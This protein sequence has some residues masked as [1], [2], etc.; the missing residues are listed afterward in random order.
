MLIWI[1][2]NHFWHQFLGYSDVWSI[3]KRIQIHLWIKFCIA[4]FQDLWK[5]SAS[6]AMW[7]IQAINCVKKAQENC[8]LA[9]LKALSSKV[10]WGVIIN[11]IGAFDSYLTN[12]GM[13]FISGPNFYAWSCWLSCKLLLCQHFSFLRRDCFWSLKLII[14]WLEKQLTNES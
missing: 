8:M 11:L 7:L 10:Q 5:R 9:Y 14:V 12:P 3:F 6:K 1:T 4:I 2:V 13:K